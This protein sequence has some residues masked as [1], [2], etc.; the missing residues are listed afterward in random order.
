MAVPLVVSGIYGLYDVLWFWTVNASHMKR[1]HHGALG[2]RRRTTHRTKSRPSLASELLVTSLVLF[3]GCVV[4][5]WL[6]LVVF[7]C[8]YY[9]LV[10]CCC[11]WWWWEVVLVVVVVVVIP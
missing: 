7:G 4:A 8:Y 6:F 2:L 11:C 1:R 3:S 9:C 5:F 10:V